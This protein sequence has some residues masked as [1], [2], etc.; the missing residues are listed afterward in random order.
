MRSILRYN[1]QERT[2]PAALGQSYVLKAIV[3]ISPAAGRI[4]FQGDARSL[5]SWPLCCVHKC[6]G[7]NWSAS[8]FKLPASTYAGELGPRWAA[9]KAA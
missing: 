1:M 8:Y 2:R 5:V 3:S 9:L 6:Q 7:C 4:C